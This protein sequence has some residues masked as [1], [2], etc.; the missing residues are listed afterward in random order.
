[1]ISIGRVVGVFGLR[2][3]LKVNPTT[4][5]R[6]RFDPGSR[7][8]IAGNRR[9]IVSA[10]WHKNQAR[11]RLTG[12]ETV[13]HAE[14]LVGHE[15]FADE[16]FVPELGDGEYRVSDLIGARVVTDEGKTIGILEEVISAPANDV[17]R[18]GEYL[19]PAV[20]TFVLNV[21]LPNKT[22]TVRVI[23]GMAGLGGKNRKR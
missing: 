14:R 9:T 8:L 10:Q 4:D 17:F 22:I 18:V 11:I 15:V 6:S 1:M 13:E 7:V 20:D 3:A 23:R 19:I 21:D 5:F 16:Q 12:V 2:G